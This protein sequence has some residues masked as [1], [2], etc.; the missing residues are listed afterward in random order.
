MPIDPVQLS[1]DSYNLQ[2]DTI[3]TADIEGDEQAPQ[4]SIG[5]YELPVLHGGKKTFEKYQSR[6][7]SIAGVIKSASI[8][9]LVGKL[10]EVKELFTRQDKTLQIL[11]PGNYPRI[12]T[13]SVDKNLEIQRDPWELNIARFKASFLCSEPWS[14]QSLTSVSGVYTIASST[15]QLGVGISGTLDPQ[16][17]IYFNTTASGS[18]FSIVNTTTGDTMDV[19]TTFSGTGRSLLID[20]YNYQVKIDGVPT[21]FKGVFPRFNPGVNNL[22]ITTYGTAGSAI[23]QSFETQTNFGLSFGSSANYWGQTFTPTRSSVLAVELSIGAN[24]STPHEDITVQIRTTSA[25][26]PTSTV[27][28]TAT[29]SAFNSGGYAW[30]RATFSAPVTVTPGTVYAIVVFSSGMPTSYFY[31]FGQANEYTGGRWVSS[32]NAGASFS[33][34]DVR[35]ALFRIYGDS[36]TALTGK[37]VIEYK[38]R[39]L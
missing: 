33:A 2:S 25:G 22:T 20:C 1:Y 3:I 16:P 15:T 38:P 18:R 37:V 6:R 13:A 27:L 39:R 21:S 30:R 26:L 14:V 36:G 35:D 10:E 5:L 23:D 19:P 4:K 8:S 24:S 17:L 12:Y 11:Y 29:I 32:S 31:Q 34:V 7:I 28:G 9:G